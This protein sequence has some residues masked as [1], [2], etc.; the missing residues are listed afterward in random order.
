MP[1]RPVTLDQLESALVT[2]EDW[3][4]FGLV[5]EEKDPPPAPPPKAPIKGKE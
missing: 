2:L 1:R 5:Q 3:A 4:R